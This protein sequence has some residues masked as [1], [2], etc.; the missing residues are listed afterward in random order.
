MDR[1]AVYVI[2]ENK[3]ERRFVR[4]GM[5]SEGRVEI[6]EGL[7]LGEVVVITGTNNLR[8]GADVRIISATAAPA[9][10]DRGGPSQ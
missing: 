5:T 10:V 7:E 4:T 9:E 1:G 6:T 2:N 8:N 3:A